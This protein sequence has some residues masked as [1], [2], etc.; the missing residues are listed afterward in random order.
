[1]PAVDERWREDEM[2]HASDAALDQL[3]PLLD[4]LRAIP[5]LRE[6]KRG[7]FYRS[8]RAFIHFH[9]SGDEQFADLRTDAGWTREP[10]TTD[11]ER[12]SFVKRV[13]AEVRST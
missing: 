4:E 8:S 1:M 10:V 7:V 13:A 9:E 5:E 12:H 11:R 3:E 2:K 6:R